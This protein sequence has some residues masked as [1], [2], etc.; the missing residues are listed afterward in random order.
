MKY[1][2]QIRSTHSPFHPLI[3]MASGTH[4]ITSTRS[5]RKIEAP[6]P[7]KDSSLNELNAKP[8][9]SPLALS[10]FA[11][12]S[13]NISLF[14]LILSHEF[15]KYFSVP[16]PE[17]ILKSLAFSLIHRFNSSDGRLNFSYHHFLPWKIDN[18]QFSVILRS[19][20]FCIASS[21]KTHRLDGHGCQ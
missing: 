5:V 11:I 10:S 2:L 15:D 3:I 18:L 19:N 4:R 6:R 12:D 20:F 21:G 8:S 14:F 7:L 13:G 16:S 1:L 17:K 9:Y